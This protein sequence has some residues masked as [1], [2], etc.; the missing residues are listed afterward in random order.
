MSYKSDP[1]ENF[2]SDA[3]RRVMAVLANPD[4]ERISF[5]VVAERLEEDDHFDLDQEEIAEILSDLEAQGD[6]NKTDEGWQNTEVGFEALT[7]PPASDGGRNYA[8]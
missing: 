3:H 7:G 8:G 4:Q 1:G 2:A 6:A 5:Q